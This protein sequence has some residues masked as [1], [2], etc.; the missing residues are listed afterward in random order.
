ML[1]ICRQALMLA[2]AGVQHNTAYAAACWRE[3][4]GEREAVNQRVGGERDD[5]K[6][7]RM[8]RAG[9]KRGRVNEPAGVE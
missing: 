8:E 2:L 3:R 4:G 5:N 6:E 9:R 1:A 7:R